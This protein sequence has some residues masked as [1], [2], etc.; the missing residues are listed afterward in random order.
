MQQLRVR[1]EVAHDYVDGLCAGDT[2]GHADVVLCKH[3]RVDR[4]V[5]KT[6]VEAVCLRRNRASARAP[7][8]VCLRGPTRRVSRGGREQA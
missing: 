2:F 5:T 6:G 3:D 7:H 4:A 1:L 8:V